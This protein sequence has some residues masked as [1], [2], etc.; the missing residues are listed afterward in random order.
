[1]AGL[2]ADDWVIDV[3]NEAEWELTA[4]YPDG[5]QWRLNRDL[6]AN[7]TPDDVYKVNSE[8]GMHISV[9]GFREWCV[10]LERYNDT[11]LPTAV[12]TILANHDSWTSMMKF[13]ILRGMSATFRF[14][15]AP[16]WNDDIG[17]RVVCR[18]K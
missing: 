13:I 8:T 18:Q 10:R 5:K 4:R 14:D 11:N 7:K 12:D 1:M 6:L 9:K 17:F 3:P 16:T 2:L 15:I